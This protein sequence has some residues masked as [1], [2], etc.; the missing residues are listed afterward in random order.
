VRDAVV[1]EPA[2]GLGSAIDGPVAFIQN[3]IEIEEYG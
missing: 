1:I 2:D 3:T